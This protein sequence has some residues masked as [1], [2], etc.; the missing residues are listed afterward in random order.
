LHIDQ[1]DRFATFILLID[2]IHKDINK[3]KTDIAPGCAIKSVHTM[4]LYELLRNPDGLTATEIATKTMIDRSLVSR[5]I[6]ALMRGGY[7]MCASSLGKRNYNSVITLTEKGKK[8]AQTIAQSALQVQNDVSYNVSADE[9][10]VFYSVLERLYNN[11]EEISNKISAG[12]Q[13]Q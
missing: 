7:V 8:I 9:L 6:S 3:I 11:I 10:H 5:E 12:E 1:A 4:W 2:A 13:K